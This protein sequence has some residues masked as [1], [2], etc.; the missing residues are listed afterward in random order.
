MKLI[1]V[2]GFNSGTDTEIRNAVSTF[3]IMVYVTVE[4][5]SPPSLSVTTTAAVAVGQIMQSMKL[6]MRM[7]TD[8]LKSVRHSSN[9]IST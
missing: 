5:M 1:V 6:S 8:S 2:S 7:S 4:A 9:T 3:I